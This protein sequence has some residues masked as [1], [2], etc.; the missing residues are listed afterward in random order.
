M[1]ILWFLA[2][3]DQWAHICLKKADRKHS[4]CQTLQHRVTEQGDPGTSTVPALHN[5]E[6]PS[7]PGEREILGYSSTS[8]PFS[9]KTLK[10]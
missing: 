4:E 7:V 3:A 9:S 10:E 5:L 8:C 2:R 6:P 1:Q